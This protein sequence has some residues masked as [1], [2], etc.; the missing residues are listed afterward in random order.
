VNYFA[1]LVPVAWMMFW[2]AVPQTRLSGAMLAFNGIVLG[3]SATALY[4]A[5]K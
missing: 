5:N 2:F 4:F 1:C 3:A